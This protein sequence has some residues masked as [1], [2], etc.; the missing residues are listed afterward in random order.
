MNL[1]DLE[2][3]YREQADDRKQPYRVEPCDVMAWLNEAVDEACVRSR[4]LFDATSALCALPII[5]NQHTYQLDPSI[6]QIADARTDTYQIQLQGIDQSVLDRSAGPRFQ[7]GRSLRHARIAYCDYWLHWRTQQG[8][9]RYFI[10]DGLNVRLVPIPVLDDTL[11]I[12]VYRIPVG[13]ERVSAR[14]DTPRVPGIYHRNLVDWMLYRAYSR[15]DEEQSDPNLAAAALERF[16]TTFGLRPGADMLRQRQE[17]RSHTT[18]IN[19]P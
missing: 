12:E 13:N 14:S 6:F 15:R 17:L 8:Q 10:R 1:A 19:W 7:S 16:E 9:P 11:R 3:T 5:A 18:V 4:L 2:A